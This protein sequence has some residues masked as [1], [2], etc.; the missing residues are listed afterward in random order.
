MKNPAVKGKRSAIFF[1]VLTLISFCAIFFL[2]PLG[3]FTIWIS[4]G[5]TIYFLFMMIWFLIPPPKKQFTRK[6]FNPQDEE[7][8]AHIAFHT[9]ILISM[10]LGA[11]LLVLVI[12]FFAM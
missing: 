3:T 7:I 9:P 8:R 10:F 6:K 4:V 1:G 11:I 12:L 5:A 2:V